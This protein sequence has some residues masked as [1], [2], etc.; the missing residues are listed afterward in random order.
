MIKKRIAL[1][2]FVVGLVLVCVTTA[3]FSQE[4]REAVELEMT[5]EMQAEMEAWMKLAQ[6][7][8]H[9]EHMK[10]Y[11]G[12][13]KGDVRMWMAPGAEPMLNEAMVDVSMI[14]DGRYLEWKQTGDF[15]GMPFE[16][17][18]IEAYNNGDARYESMWIDNFGTLILFYTGSCSDDGKSRVMT[19]QFNDPVKGGTIQYKGVYTWVDDDHLNYE[20]F[21]DKGDG[22]FKNLE[23]AYERQ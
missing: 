7:G 14:M 13:W 8:E 9:H 22:E 1:S 6:P 10:P 5:P 4:T 23:I 16:G 19:T 2:R 12:Q 21:M 3:A 17:R 11:V 18:A 15:G 20:A